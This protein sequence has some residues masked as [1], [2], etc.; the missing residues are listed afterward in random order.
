MGR[1]VSLVG[2]QFGYLQ[3]KARAESTSRRQA[4]YICVCRCGREITVLGYS[5]TTGI[6]RSCGICEDEKM[7]AMFSVIG[8]RG[9]T[10]T[11]F[12]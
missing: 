3:V 9:A 4:R 5:L 12:G 8:G 7:R 2:Y 6:K 1:L 11:N 10:E